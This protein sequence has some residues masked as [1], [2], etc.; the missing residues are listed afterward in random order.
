MKLMAAMVVMVAMTVAAVAEDVVDL[1]VVELGLPA[2]GGIPH[3]A[4]WS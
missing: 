1:L 2:S 3:T 4:S